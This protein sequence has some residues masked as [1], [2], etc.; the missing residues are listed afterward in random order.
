MSLKGAAFGKCRREEIEHH[1][2]FLQR[3]LKREGERFAAKRPLQLKSGAFAPASRAAWALR[4]KRERLR[5]AA[6]NKV[7]KRF[8]VSSIREKGAV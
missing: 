8:M 3:L 7:F 4:V 2:A 1:R 5:T 6:A